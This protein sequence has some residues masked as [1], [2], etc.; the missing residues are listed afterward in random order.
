MGQPIPNVRLRIRDCFRHAN[1]QSEISTPQSAIAPGQNPMPG[2]MLAYHGVHEQP[3]AG[4]VTCADGTT[5]HGTGATWTLS[6]TGIL[7]CEARPTPKDD[8]PARVA[9]QYCP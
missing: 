2:I 3:V 9:D 1:P 8:I 7:D 4:T 6:E 5:A